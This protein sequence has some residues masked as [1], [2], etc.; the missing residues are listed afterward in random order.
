MATR[1]QSEVSVSMINLES[2]SYLA[3]IGTVVKAFFN[4]SKDFWQSSDQYQGFFFSCQ[5][6]EGSYYPQ[7]VVDESLIEVQ[8]S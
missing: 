4:V 8:E 1:A 2:G 7:V 3:S 6:S 5:V